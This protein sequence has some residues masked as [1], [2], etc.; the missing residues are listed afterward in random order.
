MYKPL[1]DWENQTRVKL[2]HIHP[3]NVLELSC[4]WIMVSCANGLL[5][6]LRVQKLLSFSPD[7]HYSVS[8]FSTSLKE[9]VGISCPYKATAHF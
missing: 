7:L 1:L 3:I 5:N 6:S 9:L 4:N 8:P 2:P